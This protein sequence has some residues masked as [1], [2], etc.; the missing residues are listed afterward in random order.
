[1]GHE[2]PAPS[3]CDGLVLIDNAAGISRLRI[4]GTPPGSAREGAVRI[5]DL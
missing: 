1:V 5:G 4:S 3:C 2:N